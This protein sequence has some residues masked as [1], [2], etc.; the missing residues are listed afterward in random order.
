MEFCATDD[1][2]LGRFTN[3]NEKETPIITCNKTTNLK[4]DNNKQRL[5]NV[6]PNIE[7]TI[8]IQNGVDIRH[9]M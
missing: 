9:M 7:F 2:K 1:F 5:G 6:Y 3:S 8:I 4:S